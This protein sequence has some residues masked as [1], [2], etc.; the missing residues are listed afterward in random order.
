MGKM[1]V[2]GLRVS[3]D[4]VENGTM[5]VLLRKRR[6]GHERVVKVVATGTS[7]SN[8]LSIGSVLTIHQQLATRAA[9]DAVVAVG[10][11]G[12]GGWHTETPS[13]YRGRR[14]L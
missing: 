10:G 3:K 6:G 4:A 5:Q 12:G 2:D 8:A 1:M 11:G 13:C 7:C 9:L 14:R